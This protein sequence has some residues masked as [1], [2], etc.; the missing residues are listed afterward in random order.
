MYVERNNAATTNW[1]SGLDGEEWQTLT[2][3]W[4]NLTEDGYMYYE[5]ASRITYRLILGTG[6]QVLRT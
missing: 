5:E 6:L 4:R 1:A 2:F 3:R